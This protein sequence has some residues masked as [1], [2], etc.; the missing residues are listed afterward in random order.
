MTNQAEVVEAFEILLKEVEKV[1]QD[2]RQK[3]ATAFTEGNYKMATSVLKHAEKLDVF[4]ERIKALKLKWQKTFGASDHIE[5]R[6]KIKPPPSRDTHEIEYRRPILEVLVELGGEATAREA[7]DRVY[8]KVKY[9]LQEHDHQ[10]LS[11]GEV[12]WRKNAQWCR[13]HLAKEGLL[14]PGSP[15]G[16]WEITRAGRAKLSRLRESADRNLDDSLP[17]EEES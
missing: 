15:R 13:Y 3:G 7:L 10:L 12:R 14:D 2:F 8:E 6:E 4:C 5:Q 1:V 16:I 11:S 17:F 9:N